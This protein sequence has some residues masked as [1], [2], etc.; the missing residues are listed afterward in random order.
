MGNRAGTF[1]IN[2]VPYQPLQ[3]IFVCREQDIFRGCIGYQEHA[4]SDHDGV[5]VLAGTVCVLGRA[6]EE[7]EAALARI[8][9]KYAQSIGGYRAQVTIPLSPEIVRV[10]GVQ[11]M[12]R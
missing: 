11:A 9:D 2:N 6:D 7:G 1:L 4:G 8:V 12:H 10:A 3:G 5:P